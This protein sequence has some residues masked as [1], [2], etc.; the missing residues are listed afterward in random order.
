MTRNVLK[1]ISSHKGTSRGFYSSEIPRQIFKNG[2]KRSLGIITL[3]EDEASKWLF[4]VSCID[5]FHI[6]F[7]RR[8]KKSQNKFHHFADI[9][10]HFRLAPMTEH[11]ET[12]EPLCDIRHHLII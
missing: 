7:W 2:L 6:I 1:H 11:N 12:G 9:L 10:R 8:T 5:S 4:L 3:D